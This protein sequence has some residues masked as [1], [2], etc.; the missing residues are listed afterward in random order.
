[1]AQTKTTGKDQNKRSVATRNK[2]RKPQGKSKH[3]HRKQGTRQQANIADRPLLEPNAAGI[4]I[5]AREMYVAVPPDRD[6]RPVRVF[7]PSPRTCMNW[8]TGWGL[9]SNNGS[10]G[11]HR[12]VLDSDSGDPGSARNPALWG[13][14]PADEKR[15]GTAHRLARMSVDSVSAF[16]GVIAPG[17]PAR[18]AR[19]RDTGGHAASRRLGAEG[20]PTR[21]ASAQGAHRNE[22][23]DPACD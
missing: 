10:Q 15:A 17:V 7:D 3:S 19:V 9:W 2:K 5:G 1:M 6:E 23:A 20:W 16:R 22:S 4:D 11:V 14:C 18:G 21:P 13:A 8:P 12:R